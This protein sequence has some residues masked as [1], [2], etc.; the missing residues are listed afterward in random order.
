MINKKIIGYSH[1]NKPLIVVHFNNNKD[2][3]SFIN[4]KLKIFILA[5]QHGD[6]TYGPVA[7][8]RLTL[9]FEKNENKHLQSSLEIAVLIDANPD[10]SE[11]NTRLNAMGLDLNRDHLRL[12]SRE[13]EAIHSFVGYWK[14]HI[15]IDVHNYPSRR[16]HL[17]VK[18]LIYYHDIFIDIPT[19]PAS[20][21]SSTNNQLPN[22]DEII[23]DFFEFVKLQLKNQNIVCERYTIVKPSGKVRHSTIDIV[24]ARNSLSTRYNNLTI[25]LEGKNP[26]KRHGERG[27]EHIINAQIQAL[28][29]IIKWFL[30][31]KN[32]NYF[33]S[34]FNNIVIPSRSDNVAIRSRY[35]ENYQN[36]SNITMDFK[37]SITKLP[38]TIALNNYSFEL[39]VTRYIKLPYAYAVP[40]NNAQINGILKKHGFI[41]TRLAVDQDVDVEYYYYY[42]DTN[43]NNSSNPHEQFVDDNNK[44]QEIK[45]KSFLTIKKKIQ[46]LNNYTLY[47]TSQEGGH[48]LAI[49]LEP[50]SKYGLYR[51]KDLGISYSADSK[52]NFY[53][54]L[55][56]V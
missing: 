28:F 12:D 15:I 32:K 2:K 52:N 25:L 14:P 29:T 26:I 21:T 40:L 11:Q 30:I 4:P 16:K 5:G 38:I 45:N 9:L 44:L 43:N 23:T 39:K 42:I 34:N 8:S 49:L 19:N 18:N 20:I 37:D 13:A 33:L 24:D 6:E 1:L 35:I 7:A 47:H 46:T 17:I 53:P 31:P 10:G 27:K 3:N 55:R 56:I 22:Y 48:F 50:R 51:H 36:K 41:E 54:I